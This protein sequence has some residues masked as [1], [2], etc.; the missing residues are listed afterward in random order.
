VRDPAER[1][2]FY[3]P[4]WTLKPWWAGSR[5]LHLLAAVAAA[6]LLVLLLSSSL[7]ADV[8]GR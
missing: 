5:S 6:A 4:G 1:R 2:R 7:G 8:N 3:P